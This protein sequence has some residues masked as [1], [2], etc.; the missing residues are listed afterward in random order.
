MSNLSFKNLR[1][2]SKE[3]IKFK[4]ELYVKKIINL[5]INKIYKTKV[6]NEIQKSKYSD[7]ID[8]YIRKYLYQELKPSIS[9]IF[10]IKF[11]KKNIKNYKIQVGRKENKLLLK[12]IY[13]KK[14]NFIY[15][16]NNFKNFL[17]N[18]K[19]L[20]SKYFVF[21][22]KINNI[23]LV[24]VSYIEGFNAQKKN[25]L[26]WYDKKI[27]SSSEI[28]IYFQDKYLKYRHDKK[29]KGEA[30]DYFK[31]RGIK[32]ID[33]SKFQ[34]IYKVEQIENLKKNINKYGKINIY[35]AFLEKVMNDF[36]KK[37]EFWYSFFYEQNINIDITHLEVGTDIIAKKVA[38]NLLNG[39]S[40]KK[41]RSYIT[42]NDPRLIGWYN[43][44]IIFS[45]GN[46]LTK[47][48]L[49]TTNKPNSIVVT[50][51]YDAPKKNLTSKDHL[52][53]YSNK[54]KKNIL[55]LD[56]AW[57]ENNEIDIENG[58]LQLIY[59]DDYIDF[60]K[61][62]FD[63]FKYKNYGLIIKPK[64][65]SLIQNCH[66]LEEYLLTLESEGRCHIIKDAF[67]YPLDSI[68]KISHSI[69]STGIFFPTVLIECIIKKKNLNTY[70]YD[71]A[72]LKNKEKKIY[73]NLYDKVFF[74]SLD[75]L[76]D[77]MNLNLKENKN[78]FIVWENIIDS[79]N[80]FSDEKGNN[81]IANYIKC[82]R[83]NLEKYKIEEAIK[84]TNENY[85]QSWGK[86]KS[87][88]LK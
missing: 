22:L 25:D 28:L 49:R 14:I 71:Y 8:I 87:I 23:K 42:E 15:K 36:F 48:L 84:F 56:N 26:Y 64:K 37:I 55:I 30:L 78:N 63:N 82:L 76:L 66:K 38:I 11:T 19:Y 75:K 44:N 59:K 43:E 65:Y 79:I 34:K 50:G 7:D 54:F 83:S 47:R 24:G 86:D 21:K 74:N 35:E 41:I 58:N 51:Y 67:Q 10:I 72:Y 46:D 18:I 16:G 45:W 39:C 85:S 9:K 77:Q 60:Y 20:I 40:I 3:I 5:L 70:Y 27:F 62:I 52:I 17:K 88:L 33:I 32:T 81:R 29:Y 13:K 73:D 2:K 12:K 69:I 57:S 4:C 31:S 80:A 61:K 6:F 1:S 53:K 68:L